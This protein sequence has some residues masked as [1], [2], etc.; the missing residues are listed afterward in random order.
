MNK[1]L[2][3]PQIGKLVMRLSI[4]LSLI[5]M[6]VTFIIANKQTTDEAKEKMV[7]LNYLISFYVFGLLIPI[8]TIMNE[9]FSGR[10][11]KKKIITK[12]ILVS[13]VII[14]GSVLFVFFYKFRVVQIAMTVTLFLLAYVLNPTVK[15][16]QS[17]TKQ[18]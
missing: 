17:T 14:M 7:I 15:V 2:T 12:I 8:G 5:I 18:S 9:I 11:D 13:F 1:K 3:K 10:Y 6:L 16:N 4:Y